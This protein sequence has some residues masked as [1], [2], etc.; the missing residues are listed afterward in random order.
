MDFLLQFA[1]Q[2]L[3]DPLTQPLLYLE[4]FFY[5]TVK[6][7]FKKNKLVDLWNFV[8]NFTLTFASP[9]SYLYMDFL[10]TYISGSLVSEEDSLKMASIA[11]SLT[12][13]KSS[14]FSI[15]A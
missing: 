6:I 12:N 4:H 2:C 8:C 13:T 5:E 10:K 1:E 3:R 9:K 7:F 15:R 11:L 14:K